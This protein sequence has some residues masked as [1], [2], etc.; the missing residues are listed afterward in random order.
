MIHDNRGKKNMKA[1]IDYQDVANAIKELVKQ[2]GTP[3]YI[4]P[5]SDIYKF[6]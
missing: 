2:N 3:G 5:I 6:Y 1:V 4:P